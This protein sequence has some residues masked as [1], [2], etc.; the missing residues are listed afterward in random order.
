[1]LSQLM[2]F[3]AHMWVGWLSF[4]LVM[5]CDSQFKSVT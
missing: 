4:H 5:G 1:M 2:C 3:C